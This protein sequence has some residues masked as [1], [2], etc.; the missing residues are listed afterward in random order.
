M[1][2]SSGDGYIGEILELPQGCQGTFC[3]SRG[4]EGF[5]SKRHIGKGPHLALRGESPGFSQVT[6]ANFRSLSGYDGDLRDPL[7]GASGTSSIH[8]RCEG[9]LRIS[10]PSL[11]RLRSF[12][13]GKA[14]NSGFLS[15]ADMEL[16]V[17]LGRPQG[18]QASS[19]WSHASPLSSRVGK[20]LSGF[21]SG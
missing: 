16:G 12:C 11:P 14:G 3:G 17:P 9:P 2:L 1:F 10:L 4:K 15:R 8:E 5:L 6:A 20:A 19:R 7:V 13:V 21:L 18:S